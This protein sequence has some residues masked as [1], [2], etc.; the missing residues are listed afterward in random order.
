[1]RSTLGYD[2][3]RAAT[4]LKAMIDNAFQYLDGRRRQTALGV[5]A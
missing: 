2:L 4:L 5:V 3:T 1:M